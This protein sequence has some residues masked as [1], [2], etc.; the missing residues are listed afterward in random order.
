MK[1][2]FF[3][4]Q[5]INTGLFYFYQLTFCE[6]SLDINL[7]SRFLPISK[8]HILTLLS[9]IALGTHTIKMFEDHLSNMILRNTLDVV[10]KLFFSFLVLKTFIGNM[11]IFNLS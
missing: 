3:K 11:S 5:I 8:I 9:A 10:V 1:V 6:F 7:L 2:S 4:K